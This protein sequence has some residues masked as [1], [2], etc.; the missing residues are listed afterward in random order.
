MEI[1]KTEDNIIE[2][3]LC[4]DFYITILYRVSQKYVISKVFQR[5]SG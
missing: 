1:G 5:V 2:L 3:V 4:N